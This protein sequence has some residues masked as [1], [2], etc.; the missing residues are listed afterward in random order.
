M[1]SKKRFE[2]NVDL[3]FEGIDKLGG[4]HSFIRD[5]YS[6]R[7]VRAL[8]NPRLIGQNIIHQTFFS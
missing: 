4:I 8:R 6:P 2:T 1:P 7:D 5:V 3:K